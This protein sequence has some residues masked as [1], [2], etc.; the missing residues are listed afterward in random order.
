M[1]S[2]IQSFSGPIEPSAY[3]KPVSSVGMHTTKISIEQVQETMMN[4]KQI[5][6]ILRMAR[7]Y[8]VPEQAN[9]KGVI[10]DYRL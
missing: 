3:S 10:A 9:V 5:R 4:A 8:G 7:P 2:P 1:T 6:K